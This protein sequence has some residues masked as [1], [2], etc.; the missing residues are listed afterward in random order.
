MKKEDSFEKGIKKIFLLQIYFQKKAKKI[1]T[2]KK[3]AS[4]NMAMYTIDCNLAEEIEEIWDEETYGPIDQL[5]LVLGDKTWTI[6]GIR[7][8]WQRGLDQFDD[9]IARE[10]NVYF[11]AMQ[12]E[13]RVKHGKIQEKMDDIL[14]IL[15]DKKVLFKV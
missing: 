6:D 8:I 7:A 10:K 14:R 12:K 2:T 9:M 15:I 13:N 4:D 3:K 5:F 1:P 11:L